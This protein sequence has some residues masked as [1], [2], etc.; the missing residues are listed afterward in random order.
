MASHTSRDL[1]SALRQIAD[2]LDNAP[3]FT[4]PQFSSKFIHFNLFNHK[5]ELLARAR[6][7]GGKKNYSPSSLTLTQEIGPLE[8]SLVVDR[9]TICKLVSPAQEA[10]YECESIFCAEEEESLGGA[11]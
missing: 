3:E 9:S 2:K 7:L 1:S 8:V 4:I 5:Q 10:V 11:Q 6:I